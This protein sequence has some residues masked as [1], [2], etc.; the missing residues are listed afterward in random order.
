MELIT[1]ILERN[2]RAFGKDIALVERCPEK[3]IRREL[4]W[5]AFDGEAEKFS[6]ALQMRN[7]ARG[8]RVVHLMM[9][10]LEW[11]P[12]YFGILKSGCWVVPLNFRFLADKILHCCVAAEAKVILFGPEFVDRIE[13]VKDR[14]DDFVELYLFDGPEGD[15]PPFA[16]SVSAF[17]EEGDTA[18]ARALERVALDPAD[19]AALYFTSGTTGD[20]K[21]VLLTQ[22]NLA[23]SCE[24]E[25]S[26]HAQTRDDN[27]LC[28][29]PLYHTGAKM[30]WFGNFRVGATSVLLKG[31]SPKWILEAASEEK[32]SI[33]WLLV[34]WAHDILNAIDSGELD[35]EA[36]D[37]SRWRLMHIGAQPV[38]PSLIKRWMEIFP[39]HQY[40]TNYG[41]TEC[42][43]PGC[44]HLGVE[45][46]AHVGAIG[47]AGH[48][49]KTRI[50]NRNMEEVPRGEPGELVVRG[51]GVMREYY[52]NEV[53]TKKTLVDGW[54][55]TGDVAREDSH[56]MIWLLDRKKDVVITGGENI[57]PVEVENYL[58]RHEKIQD[59]AVIGTP[60]DRL[61]ELVT[62]VIQLMPGAGMTADDVK[63]FCL[64]MPR[65]R[66]P[67][68]I[69]FGEVP[70]NP[71][72]KIEKPNLR[73]KYAGIYSSFKRE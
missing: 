40:D 16:M 7:Y 49:W 51:R 64:G 3:G 69:H 57:F 6:R 63:E 11:L 59:V 26:H 37:L 29:P 2:R 46:T 45:N 25:A 56:G 21:G 28:I 55:R 50:V 18:A 12:H 61:G 5:A 13:F 70:R 42:A 10:S 44:V 33:V 4:S 67:R 36:Y 73:K 1:E 58:I 17:L 52:K 22:E 65:Y 41:L 47:V 23:F 48:G 66:R 8:T 14:L 34:P 32:C 54:L 24:V 19:A 31:V 60:D 15:R 68:I 27:F 39:N 43:G 71:T 35:L 30:H 53:E 62:A 9:N 20:P 38:P 72:G